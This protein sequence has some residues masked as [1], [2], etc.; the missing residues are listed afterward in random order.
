MDTL[1]G[2]VVII[3]GAS[4]GIGEATAHLLHE[5]GALPVLAARRADRLE[6]L[7]KKLGGALAVP[8]DVTDPAQVHALVSAA[9]DR[10]GRVDALVSNAGA[11]CHVRVEE[12]DPA[13]YLELLS[14]NVVSVVN[15]IQAVLPH[16]R[17]NGG[18]QIINVSSGSTAAVT[19]GVGAYSAT[20]CAVNML[21]EVAR[22]ELADD[23]IRVTL[24]LPS[25]TATEFRGGM[26][27][28]PGAVQWSGLIPHSPEYAGRVVLRALRTGEARIDIPH[29]P[30]Q[31]NFPDED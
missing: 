21:S 14:L 30:E 5:R 3:T 8:T 20:K 18:G 24:V 22:L 4:S 1:A 17:A 2:R 13:A 29:G 9:I 16:M 6:V 25:V 11:S 26:Y 27:A 12:I 10:H 31:P 15:G 28:D 23:N 7:G 19:P